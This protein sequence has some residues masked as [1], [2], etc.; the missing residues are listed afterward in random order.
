MSCNA[1]ILTA[2]NNNLFNSYNYNLWFVHGRVNEIDCTDL[3]CRFYLTIY[4]YIR[5]LLQ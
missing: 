1:H 5:L 4:R 3:N 2:F